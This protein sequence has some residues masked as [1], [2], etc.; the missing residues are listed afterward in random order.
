[1]PAADAVADD[2]IA[3]LAR[4]GWRELGFWYE[5]DV[6][7]KCWVFRADRKGVREFAAAVRQFLDEPES[8][9]IGEHVHLGP[10]SNL[11][12]MT[13]TAPQVSWRG[14]AGRRADFERLAEE[15]E[16]VAGGNANER[17]V[18]GEAWASGDSYRMILT[19]EEDGFD[20]ASPE[21]SVAAHDGGA[22]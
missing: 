9:Q 13:A 8:Q 14:I 22:P 18:L 21:G 1:M 11:R 2:R 3:S 19:V 5:C 12:L 10:Y 20:P 4:E 15:L 17:Q 7:R 16:R 6:N